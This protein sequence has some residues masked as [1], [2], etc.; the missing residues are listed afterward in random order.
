MKRLL[1]LF[2]IIFVSQSIYAQ[3]DVQNVKS[4]NKPVN[5]RKINKKSDYNK[6]KIKRI[7]T[8]IP[9]GQSVGFLESSEDKRA[10]NSKY[11]V[12]DGRVGANKVSFVDLNYAFS[13]YPQH[14]FG[15]TLGQ[16]DNFGWFFSVMSNFKFDAFKTKLECDENGYIDNEMHYYSDK[17]MKSRYSVIL[18][19]LCKVADPLALKFGVGYGAR[20]LAW[21]TMGHEQLVK[22]VDSSY[23][24]IEVDLGMQFFIKKINI[25]FDIITN[26]FKNYEFKFGLGLN[27]NE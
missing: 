3:V 14:S 26:S 15:L 23:N 11:L 10:T 21:E 1:V 27:F 24:G 17:V 19:F 5:V 8:V 16:V 20:A 4:R 22:N 6:R 25:S 9:S 12:K 7:K 13:L 2:F 18:G